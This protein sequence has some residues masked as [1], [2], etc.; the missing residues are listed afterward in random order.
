MSSVVVV[1]AQWGDEGKGKVVDLYA[2]HAQSVVRYAG[3]ANAGHTLVVGG[4]TLILHLIPSG[5]LHSHV[6]CIIGQGTVIDPRTLCEEITALEARGI[7]VRDRLM[8]AG[9]AHLV[10]PYHKELDCLREKGA[11]AIGTTKRG[12]GPAYQDKAARRGIRVSDLRDP[13]RLTQAV[14]DNLSYWAPIF[15]AGGVD[16]PRVADVAGEVLACAETLV[17]LMCDGVAWVKATQ[18]RGDHVLFEGAQGALLDVDHGTY[19]FVTS[20]SVTS[21]GASAACGV[22]PRTLDHV[23][24]IVKAYSTRVGEGPFPTEL[25]GEAGDQLRAWGHEYGATTGRPRRCGWL[26]LPAL[27]YAIHIN[28]IDRLAITK[29]DVLSELSELT[30]CTAYEVNGTRYEMLPSEEDLADVTPIWETVPGWKSDITAC[31][32]LED[33]PKEARDYLNK[34]EAWVNCPMDLVSVGPDRVQTLGR[35]NPFSE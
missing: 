5:I 35:L 34:I 1:G 23:V 8:V 2:Q 7:S 33:L 15:E 11:R 26:D 12:I 31:R 17:P 21:G 27:R 18:E 20:S 19:P 10:L 3:G 28:G 9:R 6:R 22:G 25:H 16:V 13:A 14:E 30:V 24:G 32:K 29:L 4:E